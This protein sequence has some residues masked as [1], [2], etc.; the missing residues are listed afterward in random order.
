MMD[1][2]N[3][4]V[5]LTLEFGKIPAHCCGNQ[6]GP[7]LLQPFLDRLV[8][9]KVNELHFLQGLSWPFGAKR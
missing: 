2:P 7:P 1:V 5:T 9:K 6:D 3:Y 4:F 8:V